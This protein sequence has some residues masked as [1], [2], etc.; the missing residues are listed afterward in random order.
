MKTKESFPCSQKP[1]NCPCHEPYKFNLHPPILF[2]SDQVELYN[3]SR[4]SKPS[5]L[6]RFRK[7]PFMDSSSLQWAI[8]NPPHLSS[9]TLSPYLVSVMYIIVKLLTALFSTS[10]TKFLPLVFKWLLQHQVLEHAQLMPF[11]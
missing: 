1:D 2:V 9:L 7:N 8:H 6:Q 3:S 4:S 5:F 11:N 10:S